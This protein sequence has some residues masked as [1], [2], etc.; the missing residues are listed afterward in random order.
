V[1]QQVQHEKDPSLLGP[2]RRA[3]ASILKPFTG[4]GDVFI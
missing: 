2:E 3:E 1:S 4:N